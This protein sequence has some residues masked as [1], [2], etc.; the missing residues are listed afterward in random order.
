VSERILPTEEGAWWAR[1]AGNKPEIVAAAR[2]LDRIVDGVTAEGPLVADVYAT[3]ETVSLDD[4]RIEWLVRVPDPTVSVLVNRFIVAH[5]APP[6]EMD[7]GIEFA[8]GG[9]P[10]DGRGV[11]IELLATAI[12]AKKKGGA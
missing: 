10:K 9:D 1:Y 8:A 11:L 6:N 4:P 2:Y 3:G 7:D 5:T 12:Y